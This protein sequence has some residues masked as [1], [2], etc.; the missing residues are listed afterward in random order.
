[1]PKILKSSYKMSTQDIN[2]LMKEAK[3]NE[4]RFAGDALLEEFRQLSE[5]QI[6]EEMFEEE[7]KQLGVAEAIHG[8]KELAAFLDPTNQSRT[9]EQQIARDLIFNGKINGAIPADRIEAAHV[10]QKTKGFGIDGIYQ[11][12]SEIR[13][14]VTGNLNASGDLD[15]DRSDVYTEVLSPESDER[16]YQLWKQN[17]T[18]DKTGRPQ[19]SRFNFNTAGGEYYGQQLLKASGFQRVKNVDRSDETKR[20]HEEGKVSSYGTDRLIENSRKLTSPDTAYSS[21]YRGITPDGRIVALDYQTGQLDYENPS[22]NLSIFKNLNFD[23]DSQK[24]AFEDN[25][26]VTAKRLKESGQRYDLDSIF[27]EMI[28]NNQFPSYIRTGYL[29]PSDPA[30]S[31][32]G[33][34]LSDADYMGQGNHD[35]Q[36][37]MEGIVYGMHPKGHR[38]QPGGMQPQDMVYLNADSVRYQLGEHLAN[39]RIIGTLNGYNFDHKLNWNVPLSDIAAPMDRNHI[40]QI[41]EGYSFK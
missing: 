15:L 1:M 38:H 16:L 35:S 9:T 21:D 29:R 12:D 6:A 26:V 30:G 8:K 27:K 28:N 23:N 3:D 17:A 31:R 11:P 39:D 7:M 25:M 33:K 36:H 14:H 32:A 40:A 18:F 19:D 24:R 20:A 37:R 5:K 22:V 13:R 2:E 10:D 4:K 41:A 34:F